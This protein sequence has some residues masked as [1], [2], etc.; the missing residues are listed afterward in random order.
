MI[1]TIAILLKSIQETFRSSRHQ[2][3][4]II[5]FGIKKA[6]ICK[7]QIQALSTKVSK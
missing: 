3:A 5:S 4:Q 7:A 6:Q 1:T 2:T